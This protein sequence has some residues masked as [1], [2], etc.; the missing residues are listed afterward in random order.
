MLN[1]VLRAFEE[2]TGLHLI[3]VH[4][5]GNEGQWFKTLFKQDMIDLEK[6][7]CPSATKLAAEWGYIYP[8]YVNHVRTTNPA[9]VHCPTAEIAYYAHWMRRN[10]FS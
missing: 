10:F 2:T 8:S 5:G 9:S 4:K 6:Y 7:G 3:G 1:N